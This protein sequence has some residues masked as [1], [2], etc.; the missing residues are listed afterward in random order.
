MKLTLSQTTRPFKKGTSLFERA[1]EEVVARS[2]E[3]ML[4]DMKASHIRENVFTEKEAK[5]K[6]LKVDDHT[7]YHGLAATR[8]RPC[9]PFTERLAFCHTAKPGFSNPHKFAK[10]KKRA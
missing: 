4:S 2:M 7:H 1:H 10:L 8:P 6:G 3:K 5:E 9:Q